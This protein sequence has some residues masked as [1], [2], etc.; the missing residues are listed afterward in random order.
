MLSKHRPLNGARPERSEGSAQLKGVEANC[1]HA[2]R[3][4]PQ[5][6]ARLAWLKGGLSLRARFAYYAAGEGGLRSGRD[7]A[8][9]HVHIAP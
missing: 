8:K 2:L 3:L 1:F 6:E 4:R 9:Q 7:R 5:G